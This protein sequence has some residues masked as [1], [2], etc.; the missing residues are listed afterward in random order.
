[1]NITCDVIKDLLPLYVEDISSNDTRKLVEEHIASCEICKKELVKLQTPKDFSLDAPSLPLKKLQTTLLKKKYLTIL[2]SVSITLLVLVITMGYLTTPEYIPYSE[3]PITITKTNSDFVS[4]HLEIPD[5]KYDISKYRSED[6][7][8]YI[9]SI[10][11][12]S[13]IWNRS[14]SNRGQ[15]DFILNPNGEPVSSVY[16]CSNDGNENILIYGN[17]Q[18]PN[19]GIITLPRLVL[20]YYFFIAVLMASILGGILF[21]F[22]QNQKVKATMF[23]LFALP[24][25]YILG[26]VCMKGFSFLSFSIAHDFYSILLAMIPIYCIILIGEKL[27]IRRKLN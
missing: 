13:S 18:N 12:W 25:S 3:Q 8:G 21:L 27:L 6:S 14:R 15:S 24:I 5:T 17:D 11:V 10:S 9:Y 26:H 1:M 2:F 7:S 4:V 23:K 22:R 19:G 20:S 16:F